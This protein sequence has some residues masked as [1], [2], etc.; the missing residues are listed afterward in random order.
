MHLLFFAKSVFWRALVLRQSPH[1]N[2]NFFLTIVS[3]LLKAREDA[4]RGDYI[5][6]YFLICQK[7]SN[8]FVGVARSNVFQELVIH[9]W[10]FR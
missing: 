1:K 4:G 7:A 10:R 9:N 3:R 6:A 5:F 2:P 8:S